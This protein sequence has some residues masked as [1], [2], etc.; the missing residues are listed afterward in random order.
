MTE[1]QRN[2]SCAEVAAVCGGELLLI[3]RA[4][5]PHAGKWGLPGG[6]VEYG[7]SPEDGA[8]REF[9]EETGKDLYTHNLRFL[10]FIMETIDEDHRQIA[11]FGHAGT[12]M[13]RPDHEPSLEIREVKWF[14]LQ[15]LPINVVPDFHQKMYYIMQHYLGR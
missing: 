8:S 10:G 3:L 6:F 5:E 7:E 11:L 12:V 4:N 15:S 14:N 1:Y 13:S 9:Y 2:A